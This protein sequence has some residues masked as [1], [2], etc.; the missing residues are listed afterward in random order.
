MAFMLD[1][2]KFDCLERGF[3]PD[4]VDAVLATRP[5]RID[6]V[7]L[8]MAA[9]TTFLSMPE[10]ETLAAAN[11]R[12]VN[13]LRKNPVDPHEPDEALLVETAE[14]T[15]YQTLV[16]LTPQVRQSID[17]QHFTEALARLAALKAPIDAFFDSLMVVADDPAVRR[18]RLALLDQLSRL[19][20]DVADLSK[21]TVKN[22]TD[23]KDQNP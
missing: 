12:I 18:N 14:K 3:T 23:N 2:L 22:T 21:L 17:Y 16:E 7:P 15:L 8:K 19:T 20:N 1:R 9:V 11:K 4:V 6:I 13:I 5:D 10:A